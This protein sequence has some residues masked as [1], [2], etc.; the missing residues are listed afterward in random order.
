MRKLAWLGV[1]AGLWILGCSSA[2]SD[3]S[4]AGGLNTGQGTGQAGSPAGGAPGSA[5]SRNSAAVG[6]TD[7]STVGTALASTLTDGCRNWPQSKLLPFVGIFFYGPD[8]G[9]CTMVRSHHGVSVTG[10]FSY[11]SGVVQSVVYSDGS[12][13][14][15]QWQGDV[16]VSTKYAN[17]EDTFAFSADKVV[18]TNSGGSQTYHL[19]ATGYPLTVDILSGA[20]TKTSATYH[21]LDCRLVHRDF[22]DASGNVTPAQTADYQYDAEGHITARRYGNG[23]EDVFDYSCWR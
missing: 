20:N 1:V 17:G 14:I 23:D 6:G 7:I 16:L 5:G 4:G 8:P 2:N 18:V 15:S 10:T 21:Y 12:S 3:A 22:L 9:P 13:E 19:S 11:V